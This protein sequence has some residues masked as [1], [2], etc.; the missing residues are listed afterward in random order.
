M[1][2]PDTLR[3][4]LPVPDKDLIGMGIGLGY[5]SDKKVN[6]FHSSRAPLDEMMKISE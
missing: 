5:A 2:Y 1:K 4:Y 3:K 6:D